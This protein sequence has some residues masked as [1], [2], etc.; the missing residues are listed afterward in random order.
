MN[1]QCGQERVIEAEITVECSIEEAF[2]AWTT[3]K[4]ITSFFSPAAR[5]DLRPGGRFEVLF[6]LEAPKGKQGSE[7]QIVMAFQRPVMFSFT[8]NSPPHLEAV[9]DQ[10]THVL[11]RFVALEPRRTRLSFRQDGW[12]HGDQWDA[13]Y[14]YFTQAW[15]KIVLP[16]FQQ[17]FTTGPVDWTRAD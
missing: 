12:G 4:G 2:E 9:R 1:N 5:V 15:L 10:R 13:A 8:W 14:D 17:L 6:D 16:R 7:D 3:E 11:L